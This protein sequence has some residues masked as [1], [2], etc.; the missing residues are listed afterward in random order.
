[1]AAAAPR[2]LTRTK[3]IALLM[4]LAT[5]VALVLLFQFI[6]GS[7]PPDIGRAFPSGEIVVGVDASFPPFALDNG[8]TIQGLDIDLARVIAAELNLPVRFRNIGFYA[9][10]DALI[11]GQVDILVSALRVDPARM[12]ELR[13]TRS[14]FD[15]GLVIARADDATQADTESLATARIAY[16]YASSAESQI[17]AWAE[18]GLSIQRLPYELPDYALDAL[19]LGLADRAIVDATTLRLYLRNH[20]HWQPRYEYI[21]HELYAI[22]IRIDRVDALKLIDSALESLIAS[23]ELATIIDQWF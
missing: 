7:V 9:L 17:R 22:A 11:S 21:T 1:M 12:D 3:S 20:R 14:Y 6:R 23:G 4:A 19:R 2:R 5:A 15:N 8:E 16:E 10:H 13:Y 18:H